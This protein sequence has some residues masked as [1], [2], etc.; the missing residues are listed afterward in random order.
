MSQDDAARFMGVDEQTLIAWE[1]GTIP[2]KKQTRKITEF[3]GY[4]IKMG[5]KYLNL[6]IIPL[7]GG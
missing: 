5:L 3:L 1:F 2:L 4:H 6:Y 7:I